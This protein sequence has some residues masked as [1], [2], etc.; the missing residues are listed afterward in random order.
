MDENVFTGKTVDDAVAEGLKALGITLADAE[1]EVLE[2]GKKKFFGSVKAKV[3]ITV[4]QS[5]EM[6]VKREVPIEDEDDEPIFKAAASAEEP[7]AEEQED[8]PAA[9]ENTAKSDTSEADAARAAK[10]ING[11]LPLLRIDGEAKVLPENEDGSIAITINTPATYKVIGK[12][13]DVLDSIQCIAGAIANIGRDKY[14]KVVVDCENYRE[15]RKESL[16]RLA[17]KLEKKAI[18]SGRK[19]ILEPMNPYERRIIHSALT[20]SPDVTTMSEGKEPNRYVVVIPSNAKP[21]DKGIKYGAQQHGNGP[22]RGGRGGYNGH[23]RPSGGSRGNFNRD[24]QS[25]GRP[26][27]SRPNGPR[28]YDRDRND[29]SND[30]GGSYNRDRNDHG[31]S[32]N[33]DRNS[34]RDSRGS[35]DSSRSGYDRGS[36]PSNPPRKKE[37]HFG[38]YL[39]NSNDTKKDE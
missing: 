29:R 28:P 9:D 36:R 15:T 14:K 4:K 3:R 39:G 26:S 6:P 11:L 19:I 22:Q 18:E 17:H 12:R 5:E 2:E 24:K 35:R 13:G 8:T 16:E 30:H 37:I 27:G 1:I 25:G 32:Y 20:D 21:Y 33:R 10:F 7:A 31:G 38:A 23:G 34:D